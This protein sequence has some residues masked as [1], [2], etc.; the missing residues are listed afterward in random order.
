MSD[1]SSDAARS[2]L[3]PWRLLTFE[4][5]ADDGAVM[6]PFGPDPKGSLIYT[7]A[8]RYSAQV[9]RLDRQRFASG[10]Q[11]KGTAEEVSTAFTGAISYFGHFELD[12][13]GGYVV[14]HVESSLFPNWEGE[15][16]KRFYELDLE[17]LRI[18]TPPTLW[19][20]G[21]EVVAVLEWERIPAAWPPRT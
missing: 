17:R 15:G 6:R 14:Q 10:D 12:A 4:I 5:R 21:G 3:G 18:R 9:T 20:G 13:E 1:S 11:M 8:G 19:G 7:S 16:Q 2:L